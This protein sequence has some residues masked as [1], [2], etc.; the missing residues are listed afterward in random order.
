MSVLLNF[1]TLIY[2]HD[3]GYFCECKCTS[4][5]VKPKARKKM[6]VSE[7]MAS[8][9]NRKTTIKRLKNGRLN[10]NCIFQCYRSGYNWLLDY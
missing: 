1:R 7:K 4:S 5:S 3:N 10:L 8:E 2:S 6:F 9:I